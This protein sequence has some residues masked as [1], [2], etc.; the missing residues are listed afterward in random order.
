MQDARDAANSSTSRADTENLLD[1]SDA[2]GL[3]HAT[4]VDA[5]SRYGK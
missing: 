2:V 5:S 4:G 1:W 3:G